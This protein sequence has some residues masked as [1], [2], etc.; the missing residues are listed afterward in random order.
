MSRHPNLP[1]SAGC[2]YGRPHLSHRVCFLSKLKCCV[3]H[4]FF[5]FLSLYGKCLINTKT[6]A[7]PVGFGEGC[8]NEKER[9]FV[10][11]TPCSAGTFYLLLN[12]LIGSELQRKEVGG[13]YFPT[14]FWSGS[15]KCF[16]LRQACAQ[17]FVFLGILIG[18]DATERSVSFLCR[19]PTESL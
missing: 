14:P 7:S 11:T 5:F 18:L 17:L 19:N 1:F 16:P 6:R 4:C 8:C 2:H 13:L 15:A 10:N 9:R 12:D 3:S